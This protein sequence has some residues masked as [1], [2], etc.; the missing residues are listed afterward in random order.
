MCTNMS[1][2]M[3]EYKYVD[4]NVSIQLCENG[5]IIFHLLS[6]SDCSRLCGRCLNSK[7]PPYIF[8][9]SISKR[10]LRI[11]EYFEAVFMQW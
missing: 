11:N 6:M 9:I 5:F 2:Q 8:M 7:M 1:L 10:I 4:I 3:C